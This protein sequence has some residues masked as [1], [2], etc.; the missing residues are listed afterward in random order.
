MSARGAGHVLAIL[1]RGES[2]R[3]CV[4]TGCLERVQEECRLSVMSVMP[5]PA[6]GY[7]LE[8]RFASIEPLI[9]TPTPTAALSVRAV[10]DIAHGRWLDSPAARER[11][12]RRDL[13][14]LRLG[15]RARR[16]MKQSLSRPFASRG[17]LRL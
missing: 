17:G 10:S 8:R 12:R 15:S 16:F 3:N 6:V 14:A 5:S 9:S 4:Y 2:I 7:E 1:P 11:C 13:D